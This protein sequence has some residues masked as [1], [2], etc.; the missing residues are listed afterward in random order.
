MRIEI[1][2]ELIELVLLRTEPTLRLRNTLH[3][4]GI[5]K[6]EGRQ[7]NRFERQAKDLIIRRCLR[8]PVETYGIGSRPVGA[9]FVRILAAEPG[10]QVNEDRTG[11]EITDF[12]RALNQIVVLRESVLPVNVANPGGKSG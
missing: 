2:R 12:L 8:Q 3:R 4:I 7:H 11:A 6:G 1:L 9:R 10:C 5:C